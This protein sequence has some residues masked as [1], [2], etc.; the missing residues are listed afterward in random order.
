MKTKNILDKNITVLP[1]V[2]GYNYHQG[3]VDYTQT[4]KTLRW[5]INLG[6]EY[7]SAID[8]LRS[9]E[10]HSKEQVAHKSKFPVW[11][12]GGV[13]PIGNTEDKDILEYSNLL[14]I[15][16]DKQ[17]NPDIDIEKIK[18][19]LFDLPYVIMVSKSIS[20]KG[21]YVLILVEDGKYTKEYYNYISKLWNQTYKINID[22]KCK[23]IGRKRFL[24]YDDELLIKDDD[25]DIV[26]W[27][28]K[29]KEKVVVK[30]NK[31]SIN[32]SKYQTNDNNDLAHK[33][34]WYLLD[35]GFSIDDFK[36]TNGYGVWYHIGC[37][38]R[39]FEDG[40]S[41]FTTF[42]NNSKQYTDKAIDI[43]KKWNNTKIE[44]TIDEVSKKWC[45]ICK[46]LYG[47][48]WYKNNFS[49]QLKF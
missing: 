37:D 7:K 11:F 45:G 8:K 35:R 47:P 17:D 42:S 3:L 23:N 26:P 14:A 4:T 2:D 38:F 46:N 32:C 12:V 1:S 33:A 29:L 21:I 31:P 19:T 40:E 49:N 9:F 16:I 44:N 6:N 25:V 27:K 30:E 5:I 39:H 41:M 36:T 24:S 43:K 15:D 10:Y 34:I 20:G 22:E 18:N 48:K 13:F 28:L